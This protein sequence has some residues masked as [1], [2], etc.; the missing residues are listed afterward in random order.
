LDTENSR[1]IIDLLL[2]LAHEDGYCVIVVTHDL[3]IAAR[4]D[5]VFR[6]RDGKL[7]GGLEDAG[8]RKRA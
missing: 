2:K 1:R 5:Q 6:M 7:Q 8:Y 4:A 3:D